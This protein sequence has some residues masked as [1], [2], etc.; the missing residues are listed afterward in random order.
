[1]G[2]LVSVRVDARAVGTVLDARYDAEH[3][4]VLVELVVNDGPTLDAIEERR[5][6]ALSEA[7]VPRLRMRADGV[8]EQLARRTN[9]ICL[10]LRGRMPG[11]L[12]RADDSEDTMTEDQIRSVV[13]EVLAALRADEQAT[14]A[15]ATEEE[16]KAESKR[17]DDAEARADAAEAELKTLR[18]A[19]GVRAD[20][21]DIDA[22]LQERVAELVR[23]DAALLEEAATLQ[24]SL[25]PTSTPATRLRDLAVELGADAAR[26][27]S[28]EYARSYIDGR[29]SAPKL[30][31]SQRHKAGARTT[32]QP[33]GITRRVS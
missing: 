16:L 30:T 4:A 17:A 1:M 25:P 28:A 27:D 15:D 20:G 14:K 7:Y 6:R 8:G 2:Q 10:V 13:R 22:A 9:H 23:A 5:L 18:D 11:A 19:V 31:A 24:V 33:G 21:D 3:R 29:A 12:L 32:Q 26:A